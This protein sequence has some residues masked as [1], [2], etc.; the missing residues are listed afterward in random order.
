MGI[1][2]SEAKK[3]V[4]QDTFIPLTQI[5]Y[6]YCSSNIID[7]TW[8]PLTKLN[9][10]QLSLDLNLSRS[11][12]KS[13]MDM[14][15]RDGLIV[16]DGKKGFC[17]SKPTLQGSKQLMEAR[18][19]I[20]GRA[21]FLAAKSITAEQLAELDMLIRKDK[22][23]I[24]HPSLNFNPV[25]DY[26]IHTLIV[27]ATDN[28]YLN[29]MYRSISSQLLR[30]RYFILH[31]TKK[32]NLRFCYPNPYH[33]SIYNALKLH[34]SESARDEIVLDIQSMLLYPF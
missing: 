18:I 2:L 7:F 9:A 29:M 24:G 23:V 6:D 21:A 13:A 14:L 28:H 5:V 33:K 27:R 1:S 34:L 10:Y 32:N 4:A 11:P 25:N 3:L 30:H 15:E 20:E 31:A 26:D 19:A 17:V 8:E 22:R 12:V 16:K